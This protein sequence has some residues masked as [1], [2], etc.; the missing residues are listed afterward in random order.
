MKF[1]SLLL[2]LF[3]FACSDQALLKEA[4]N[5]KD[6]TP[7]SKFIEKVKAET[8]TSAERKA[9]FFTFMNKEIPAYWIGTKWDY[10][11]ITRIPQ[12]KAIACGYFVTTVL[13]DFGITLKRIYLAQQASS[14]MINE[15]CEKTSVKHF[16]SLAKVESYLAARS[17]EEVYIV[18]LDFHTGFIIRDNGTNYFF[19][20]NYINKEGVIKEELAESKAFASSES[21]MIGS[22][23]AN[24]K[25]FD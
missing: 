8:G 24:S 21:F 4:T 5:S 11:G 23:S 25:L 14:V 1:I 20:S 12:T 6:L 16:A 10:N 19:H 2:L 13:E 17:E 7:Y 22:L 3:L 18:G 15:L 9:R